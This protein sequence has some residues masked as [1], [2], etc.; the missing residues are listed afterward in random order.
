MK[1]MER[2][3]A[4]EM[5]KLIP[6]DTFP[7]PNLSLS[8]SSAIWDPDSQTY[9]PMRSIIIY[10]TMEGKDVQ[11][12]GATSPSCWKSLLLVLEQHQR[13]VFCPHQVILD[14]WSLEP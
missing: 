10:S 11:L 13:M 1:R 7:P 3:E 5:S 8:I 14:V 12:E 2:Q 9:V 4:L 6:N